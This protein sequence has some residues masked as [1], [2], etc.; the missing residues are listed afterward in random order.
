MGSIT[1]I[2]RT[3]LRITDDIALSD[4]ERLYCV[5]TI[6]PDV[7]QGWKDITFSGLVAAANRMALW[8]EENVAPSTKPETLAY[9]ATND[10]RYVAF[11]IAC[12]RLRHT[13]SDC[14]PYE[15]AGLTYL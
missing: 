7:S 14:P 9:V 1:P 6:S 8:I 11:I 13:V 15:K 5:Q 2:Q 10:V 12:M 3:L 4:P